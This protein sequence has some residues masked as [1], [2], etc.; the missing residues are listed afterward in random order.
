MSIA[1]RGRITLLAL[2]LTAFSMQAV[3]AAETAQLVLRS[4]QGM[5]SGYLHDGTRIVL[6][7]VISHLSHTAFHLWGDAQHSDTRPTAYFLTGSQDSRHQ[8]RVRL[9]SDNGYAD[10]KSGGGLILPTI[11]DEASFYLVID[12][13]QNV[14]ADSYSFGFAAATTP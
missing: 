13:D 11:N 7:R 2:L 8:L 9:E 3:S 12:G 5:V 14:I 10:D 6:G 4:Q 1:K